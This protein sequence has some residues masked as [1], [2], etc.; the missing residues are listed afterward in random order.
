MNTRASFIE[1]LQFSKAHDTWATS[2]EFDQLYKLLAYD[3]TR[4]SSTP[5]SHK[6]IAEEPIAPKT[7]VHAK[8]VEPNSKDNSDQILRNKLSHLIQHDRNNTFFRNLSKWQGSFSP[9]QAACI[10]RNYNEK[11]PT[12]PIATE[13]ANDDISASITDEER[14]DPNWTPF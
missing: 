1:D 2:N 14:N 9:K 10:E 12:R 11:F 13:E 5:V 8:K 4:A 6:P 7:G 3:R